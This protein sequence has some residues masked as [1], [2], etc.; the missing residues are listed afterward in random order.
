[1]SVNKMEVEKQ[2]EADENAFIVKCLLVVLDL[3]AAQKE[4]IVSIVVASLVKSGR[5]FIK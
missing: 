5:D 2:V 3:P 4:K 1:M